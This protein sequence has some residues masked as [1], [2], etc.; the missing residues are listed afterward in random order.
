MFR[1]FK[2]L[3]F[4][5]PLIMLSAECAEMRSD[6]HVKRTKNKADVPNYTQSNDQNN[7]QHIYEPWSLTTEQLNDVDIVG[8][9]ITKDTVI[10]L[11]KDYK[12]STISN[13]YKETLSNIKEIMECNSMSP[14][15]NKNILKTKASQLRDQSD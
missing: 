13:G 3:V 6:I 11:S 2:S 10:S 12:C 1:V 8:I 7:K 14:C 9:K 4:C 15:W 5:L